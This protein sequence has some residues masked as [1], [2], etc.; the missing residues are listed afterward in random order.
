MIFDVNGETWG[1]AF[2]DP[3]NSV[4]MR[5]DGSFSIAVTDDTTKTISISKGIS[6]DFLRKVISHEICHVYS[7]AYDLF[8]PIDIEEQIADFIATYGRDV[9]QTADEIFK[10]LDRLVA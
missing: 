1:I 4:L 10:R 6:G 3:R 7:F 2:V 9:L 8:I 5:S